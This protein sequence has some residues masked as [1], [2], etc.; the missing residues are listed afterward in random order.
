MTFKKFC[1]LSYKGKNIY[2]IHEGQQSKFQVYPE[3]LEQ[4]GSASSWL[5]VFWIH[6]RP[7]V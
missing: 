3:N 1:S 4:E 2:D 7:K 5:Y 6:S